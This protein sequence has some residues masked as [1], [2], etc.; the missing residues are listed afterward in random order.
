[1]TYS[2]IFAYVCKLLPYW[3]EW[4]RTKCYRAHLWIISWDE[5]VWDR[6]DRKAGTPKGCFATHPWPEP[7]V[8]TPRWE[9]GS[10]AALASS[11]CQVIT[12]S[13]QGLWLGSGRH[14]AFPDRCW[15]LSQAIYFLFLM[16]FTICQAL[17]THQSLSHSHPL[18]LRAVSRTCFCLMFLGS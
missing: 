8:P 2:L 9:A 17:L 11:A 6:V 1:M 4:V 13:C 12:V 10:P 18:K 14:P 3:K 5:C 15:Q 7:S 16:S